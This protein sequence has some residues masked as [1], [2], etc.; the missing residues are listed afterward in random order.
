MSLLNAN[1]RWRLQRAAAFIGR[2]SAGAALFGALLVGIGCD[3]DPYCFGASCQDGAETGDGG[4]AASS[5]SGVGG[6]FTSSSSTSGV[7]GGCELTNGGNEICDNIDNNCD[8]TVDEE[9]DFNGI[10]TCG[11]CDNNCLAQLL[12]VDPLSITCDWNGMP[13][14]AGTCAFTDCSSDF[15]DLD[16]NLPGCEYYCFQ[17]AQN[18]TICD[19]RDD[20]CDGV[21]DED[22]DLCGDINNCGACGRSCDV[23]HGTGKCVDQQMTPCTTA[24]TTCELDVCE[25][26]WWDLDSSYGTGCEYPCTLTNNG[27]EICGDGLDNDCD[28]AIDGVDTDL[29]GDPQIGQVCFGDPDGLCADQAHSGLTACVGQQVDCVGGNVLV[30]NQTAE[31]CNNVDDD[32][33]GVVDD[34]PGDAGMTCGTSNVFPCSLGTQ[35]CQSGSLVCVGNIEPGVEICNGIDDDCDTMVDDNPTDAGG[36]CN[37]PIPPPNGATSPCVAGTLA[38]TAGVLTCSGFT[39]PTSQNDG[40]SDDSNCDG[41]LT[42]QPDLNTD[43]NNCGGCGT[44]C[45]SIQGLWSCNSGTCQFD[46]CVPGYYD[47]NTGSD[48][49][50]EYACLNTGSEVCDGIDNDCDGSIDIGMPTPSPTAVCGVS[51]AATRAEC[52]TG[53]SISCLSGSWSCSFPAGVCG[54]SC[55]QATE[56]CD[57]LDNDCDGGFNENVGNYGQGCASDV[58]LPPPGHGACQTLGTYVCNGP[59]ATICNATKESC[60]NIPGGCS[61]ECD[62]VDN[63]CDGLVDE[64]YTNKGSDSTYFVKPAV[65]QFLVDRWVMTY[66]ATRPNATASTAGTG[67]G[68][69]CTTNSCPPGIPAAPLNTVLEQTIACSVPSALPWFNVTPREVEQTC[70][71]IGGFV[72]DLSEWQTSCEAQQS[73]DWGYNTR[74]APCNSAQNNSKYCNVEPYDFDGVTVG[75]QDGLLPGGSNLLANCWADWSNLFSNTEPAL[76]DITGNLR[77]I[78]KNGS[79]VYPLMGGAFNSPEG[80]STCQFDFYAVD[81]D[82]ALLDTGFRCCFDSDPRL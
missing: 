51:V 22:V 5:T 46:G 3:N 34:N 13:G 33:D 80:G 9:I 2:L 11:T 66:E 41:V 74:G 44:L 62:G 21:R 7:G 69:F 45:S 4:A 50:C 78:T 26:G 6:F 54:P 38:C 24:N 8:G 27:V 20:D 17:V 25:T 77:E 40:C 29:S 63:D 55:S 76:F 43:I 35:Q 14:E 10:Q 70:D 15:F 71:A 19:N 48:Q 67:N 31:T 16:T 60:V 52:T 72:C 49:D 18:D 64:D 79:N 53:V 12:N 56:I 57:N 1:E 36:A 39:G 37:V 68:Y 58:G 73:C 59:N 47:I 82:F 42:G 81:Q 61:E 30:E 32:C 65:T 75:N 23:V 28:G